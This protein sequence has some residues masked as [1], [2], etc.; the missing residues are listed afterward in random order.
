M[1]KDHNLDKVTTAGLLVTLGIIFGDI[2]T[3]PLYVLSA[4]IGDSVID[5]EIVMGGVSCIFWTLTLQTSIKYVLITLKAD[6][7]G[8]GGI[9]SLYTLVRRHAKWLLYPTII[10]GSTLLADSIITPSI[11]VTTAIEELTVL[12]KDIP[13]LPIVIVIIT[14]L[15]IFQKFGTTILGKSFGPVMFAWFTMLGVLGLVNIPA[16]WEILQA[17][18]PYYAFQLILHYPEGFWLLGAVF[19]CTTGAEALYSDLGHC[20]RYNIQLSWMAVKIGL[21]LNYFGQ[22]AWLLNHAGAGLNGRNPFYLIMPEWFLIIGIVIA[23]CAVIVASQAL[24]TGSFTLINEAIRLNFWPKVKISYPTNVK[25]QIYIP[26]VNWLLWAGCMGVVFYF[27]KSANMTAAYGLSIIITMLMTTLLV[28][29]YLYIKRTHKALVF[30][31]LIIYAVV[32]LTFLIANLSKFVHGGWIT[33]VIAALLFS[34]M[35]ICHKSRKIRNKYIEFVKI[36]NY[37]ELLDELSKDME[38]PKYSTHLVYLTS[39]DHSTDIESKIIYSIFQKQPKRADVYWFIHVDV[40]DKPYTMEYKVVELVKGKV[41]RIEFKLGFRVEPRIN[42]MFRKVV[43]DVVAQHEVDISSR[44]G[45]LNKKNLIGDFR[46]VVLEKFLSY[47]NDLPVYER[48]IM[49]AYFNL[50]EISLTEEKAFGLDT[51]SVV[52]EKVPMVIKPTRKISLTRVS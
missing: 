10:G 27:R 38:V 43:E 35:W 9:F 18:N 21:L 25:G 15:F 20:G 16:N 7:H 42:L 26:S 2:G 41:I 13:I 12:N 39:A 11:S 23:A 36:D 51:S 34:V 14:L 46:F 37:L 52:V 32:E 31:F 8:E 40:Q 5:K 4:I 48:M 22:G 45:S 1:Q 30:T 24:I 29:Y 19:L 3:S 49:D 44:Y 50:K 17:L 28:T 47:D 6:N 33:P